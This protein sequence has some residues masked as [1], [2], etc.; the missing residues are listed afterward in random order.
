MQLAISYFF[1]EEVMARNTAG[2]LNHSK[3][4]RIKSIVI[5]KFAQ[6]RSLEDQEALWSKSKTANGQKCKA[7]RYAQFGGRHA[8]GGISK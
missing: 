2:S 6:K 8:S 7:L 3:M 1:G 4:Q 5:S